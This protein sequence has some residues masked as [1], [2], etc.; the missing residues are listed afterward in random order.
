MNEAI[1]RSALAE[2]EQRK[3]AAVQEI[4]AGVLAQMGVLTQ[5]ELTHNCSKP[6]LPKMLTLQTAS[7]TAVRFNAGFGLVDPI[8]ITAMAVTVDK[9]VPAQEQEAEL[10]VYM[11]YTSRPRQTDPLVLPLE[12]TGQARNAFTNLIMDHCTKDSLDRLA[13]RNTEVDRL[14]KGLDGELFIE[15]RQLL[16]K[17]EDMPLSAG[18]KELLGGL[19]NLLDDVAD[20]AHD[21]YGVPCLMVDQDDDNGP[22]C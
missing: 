11:T 7:D 4:H 5:L 13:E 12:E 15:Q 2:L 1:E 6:I 20:I 18:E 8:Y 16:L 21:Q 14:F 19:N 10:R 17:M 22:R 9:N 3:I